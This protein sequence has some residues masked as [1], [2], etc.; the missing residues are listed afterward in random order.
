MCLNSILRRLERRR[1]VPL[2]TKLV[3]WL[4]SWVVMVAVW[5]E[6]T[7]SGLD[8][9]FAYFLTSLSKPDPVSQ[10]TRL[11]PVRWLSYEAKL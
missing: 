3:R 11:M 7:T 4:N 1:I 8:C 9:V 2:L 5:C 10:E 6:I